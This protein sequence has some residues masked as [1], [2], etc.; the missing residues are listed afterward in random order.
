[1]LNTL[2]TGAYVCQAIPLEVIRSD[3]DVERIDCAKQIR[4]RA[5]IRRLLRATRPN[6]FGSVQMLRLHLTTTKCSTAICVVKLLIA[7]FG[8]LCIDSRS[9]Q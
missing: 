3:R 2:D 9:V 5:K 1:M 8:Q 4:L 7:S 6:L